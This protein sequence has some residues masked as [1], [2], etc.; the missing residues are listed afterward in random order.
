M[1]HGNSNIKYKIFSFVVLPTFIFS[2]LANHD[3]VSYCSCVTILNFLDVC[4]AVTVCNILSYSVNLLIKL[5]H[6]LIL[7]I[8]ISELLS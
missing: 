2:L 8:Y 4:I 7:L 1:M 5:A 6:A 3:C